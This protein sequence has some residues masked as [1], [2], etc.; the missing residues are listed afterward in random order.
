MN[1]KKKVTES[2]RRFYR[3]VKG[4]ARYSGIRRWMKRKTTRQLRQM[5]E[6]VNA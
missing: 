6:E 4:K 5:L 2:D 3:E 1:Q